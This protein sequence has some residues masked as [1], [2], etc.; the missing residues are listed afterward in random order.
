MSTKIRLVRY[1]ANGNMCMIEVAISKSTLLYNISYCA[2][3]K[4]DKDV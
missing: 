3:G 1:K 4:R 2:T